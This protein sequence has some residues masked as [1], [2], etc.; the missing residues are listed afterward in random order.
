LEFEGKNMKEHIAD[1]ISDSYIHAP[2]FTIE[3]IKAIELWESYYDSVNRF[4]NVVCTG[5]NERG[6]SVPMNGIEMS[7][8]NKYAIHKRDEIHH[9]AARFGIT[10]KQMKWAKDYTLRKK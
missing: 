8:I 1:A 10:V 4:D 2:E 7:T 5:K 9:E 6:I 3:E